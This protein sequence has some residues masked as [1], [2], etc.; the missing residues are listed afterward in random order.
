MSLKTENSEIFINFNQSKA[1]C[2]FGTP[3]GFYIYSLNPLRKIHH[4]T[5]YQVSIIEYRNIDGLD[6]NISQIL[7]NN[8]TAKI[9][10]HM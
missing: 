2:C 6:A 8:S 3:I 4:S 10:S 5:R 9:A 1:Y 7:T